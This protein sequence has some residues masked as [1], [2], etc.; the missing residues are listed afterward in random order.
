MRIYKCGTEVCLRLESFK[1][2]ITAIEIRG[3]YIHYEC[4][5]FDGHERKKNWLRED[6]F[7]TDTPKTKIGFK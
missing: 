6:E 1:A 2:Y 3:E 4:T 7:I 5:Y